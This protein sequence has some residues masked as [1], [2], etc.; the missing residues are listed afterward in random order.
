MHMGGKKW[1]AQAAI[2]L[3]GVCMAWSAMPAAQ[4]QTPSTHRGGLGR[5]DASGNVVPYVFS[6]DEVTYDDTLGITI[7]RG[8]VEM[9]QGGQTVL[10]DVVAYNQ[11]TDTVTASGHV[12]IIPTTGV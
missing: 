7:A 10:A 5:T 3:A 12:T 1:A 2:G 9:S 8:N 6:A 11:H 4:A